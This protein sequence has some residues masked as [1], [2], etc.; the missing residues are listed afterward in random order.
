MFTIIDKPKDSWLVDQVIGSER[1]QNLFIRS[2]IIT[3]VKLP[4]FLFLFLGEQ[5]RCLNAKKLHYV[6]E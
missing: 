6:I 1:A 5:Y 3:R 2:R 4:L